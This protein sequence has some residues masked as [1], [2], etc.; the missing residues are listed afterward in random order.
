MTRKRALLFGFLI[1]VAAVT[2]GVKTLENMVQDRLETALKDAGFKTAQIETLKLGFKTLTAR[3]IRLDPYGFTTIRV[4]DVG[5]SWPGMTADTVQLDGLEISLEGQSVDAAEQAVR[6]VIA[7]LPDAPV[8]LRNLKIDIATTHGAIRLE[9]NG[10]AGAVQKDGSRAIHGSIYAQQYQLGF[11]SKWTGRAAKDGTLHLDVE[12]A[13]GRLAAGP[14]HLSRANGWM[15]LESNREQAAITG[16]IDAGGG[17]LNGLPLQGIALTFER[18]T[19]GA[20]TLVFRARGGDEA[21]V[22]FSADLDIRPDATR[23]TAAVQANKGIDLFSFIQAARADPPTLPP[24]LA[25]LTDIGAR[26]TY[27]PDR[28]FAGGPFPFALSVTRPGGKVLDGTVLFYPESLDIR[29]SAQA[30]ETLAAD[31]KT[32]FAIPDENA[33]GNGFRLDESLRSVLENDVEESGIGAGII[34]NPDE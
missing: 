10:S 5:I 8:T 29:G 9:G 2:I 3:S 7:A 34:N 17:L 15:A 11:E 13:D 22:V 18:D 31:L 25:G 30:D 14:L 26:L 6:R 24:S 23:F 21:P 28:R 19:K 1:F 33:S 12:M 16:Q 32:F 4:L 27:Q 20:G